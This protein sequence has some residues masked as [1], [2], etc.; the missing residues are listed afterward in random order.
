MK[1]VPLQVKYP[2]GGEKQLIEAVLA[3]V[4]EYCSPLAPHDDC[5]MI[6]LRYLGNG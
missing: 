2:Q 3:D 5:T 6:A 4:D 1:V